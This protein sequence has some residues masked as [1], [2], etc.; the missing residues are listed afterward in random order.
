MRNKKTKL[1][2]RS[3]PKGFTLME[4]IVTMAIFAIVSVLMSNI[5]LSIAAFSI[6]NEKKTDFLSELDGVANTIKNDLRG[7]SEVGFCNLPDTSKAIYY[8]TTTNTQ[9]PTPRAYI[10]TKDTPSNGKSTRVI[11]KN[12][13]VSSGNC[14]YNG[15]TAP[16]IQISTPEI[17]HITNVSIAR[18]CDDNVCASTSKN[19]LL[20]VLIEACDPLP[21]N[22]KKSIFDCT[23]NPYRYEMAITTRI[24]Q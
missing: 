3:V 16:M 15:A 8:K 2:K 14:T 9:E 10:L 7:A 22:K 20:F 17:M 23:E 6:Q 11:W 24:T 18:S 1:D 21:Q 12:V 4:L 19:T 13:V 5:V